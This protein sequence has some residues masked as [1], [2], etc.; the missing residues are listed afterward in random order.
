V[1]PRITFDLPSTEFHW[2]E[3]Q[4]TAAGLAPYISTRTTVEWFHLDS[5]PD[6]SVE[7]QITL[8][9]ER[10]PF[11]WRQRPQ[12]A[13]LEV[14]YGG[15]ASSGRRD[16]LLAILDDLDRAFP[17]RERHLAEPPPPSFRDRFAEMLSLPVGCTLVLA[18]VCA[19]LFLAAYG[20]FALLQRP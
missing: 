20:V 4:L 5:S 10:L 9:G 8:G 1:A 3:G 17:G 2:C 7:G 15:A 6:V 14:F 12:S 18:V 16:W 13:E 19:I 11:T